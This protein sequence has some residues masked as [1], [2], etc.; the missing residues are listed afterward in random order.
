VSEEAAPGVA[1][2]LALLL[3]TTVQMVL[4]ELGPK[5]LAIARPEPLALGLARITQLYTR[6]AGPVIR[7]FDDTTNGLLRALGVQPAQ[8]L[9]EGASPE[10]LGYIIEEARREGAL[11]EQQTVL[12]SRALEFRHLR[13][14]D[15]MVAR[16]H[17]VA[18]PAD[19]TCEDLR[20]LAVESGHSRF[21]LL[22]DGLDDVLG[23]VLARDV[24]GVPVD[25]RAATPARTL[26]S[27]PLAVPESAPLRHLLADLGEAH[28]QLAVVVDEYGGTAG[29]VT[30][31]DIVEELVGDI[32]DEY[33]DEEPRAQRRADGSALVPGAWRIDE[34]EREVGVD[35]PHGDYETVGGLVMAGLGRIPRVG[36]RVEL[37]AVVLRVEEM[38]GLAVGRVRIEPRD[39][40]GQGGRT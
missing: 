31:E 23:V 2:T 20:A 14:I 38:D 28:V 4:G 9:S 40:S 16:P 10:E 12:L 36:D 27:V 29:I 26:A 6:I 7:L 35:L 25:R 32:E 30:L 21:P 15:A 34:A 19:A 17:V 24:L 22:G 13:A 8:E 3:V 5:N 11:T 39:G 33:D 1:L 37:D 18:L